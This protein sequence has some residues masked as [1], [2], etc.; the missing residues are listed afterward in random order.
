MCQKV[1]RVVGVGGVDT[2][3]GLFAL[4]DIPAN[5][6]VCSYAPTASLREQIIS[7]NSMLNQQDL[8]V[9]NIPFSLELSNYGINYR[10]I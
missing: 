5:T 6:F 1:A 3:L 4:K 8:I 2:G 9:I 10:V 7:T